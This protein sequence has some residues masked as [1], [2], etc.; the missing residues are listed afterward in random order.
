MFQTALK[1]QAIAPFAGTAAGATG[2][3][4]TDSTLSTSTTFKG[5]QDKYL[6][7]LIERE[8]AYKT[9]ID[10]SL[11]D[12]KKLEEG[13]PDRQNIKDRIKK[14]T[15]LGMAQAF[16][17]AAAGESPNFITALSQGLGGAAGVLNKMT[18]QEQ[19]ELYQHALN[20]FQREK[21][22]ANTLYT[23][24][25][26]VTDKITA[27]REF[28]QTSRI[29]NR[30][31]QINLQKMQQDGF[32]DALRLNMD[33]LKTAAA[34][35]A[36]RDEFTIEQRRL[37][38]ARVLQAQQL[39]ET[40]TDRATDLQKQL[41]GATA[42]QI[43]LKADIDNNFAQQFV[44]GAQL[45]INDSLTRLISELS[46]DLV[47]VP[48]TVTDPA[49]RLRQAGAVLKSRLDREKRIGDEAVLAE[50]GDELYRIATSDDQDAALKQF[51]QSPKG[52][53]I[54]PKSLGYSLEL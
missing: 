5:L 21:E 47:N 49:Q 11:R 7:E 38:A 45:D 19:K 54:N 42:S 9:Q 30:N 31:A 24:Q 10:T 23:R 8:K 22:R 27:A 29:A 13:L 51:Y 28:E 44:K 6:E 37:F 43:V 41:D 18:G 26:D 20:E 32:Y 2:G 33:V 14:Q 40:I 50:Y 15:S 3:T 34:E 48:D 17:Q 35:S 1:N 52:S 4:G 25:K 16:F 39:R 36:A 53:F 12:L 46:N